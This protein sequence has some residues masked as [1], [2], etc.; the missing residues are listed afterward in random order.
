MKRRRHAG[1]LVVL[2]SLLVLSILIYD[3][4]GWKDFFFSLP[5]IVELAV[6]LAAILLSAALASAL[7]R[8]RKKR[9]K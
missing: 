7:K 5:L 6:I 8:W 2:L 3:V 1:S 4:P 9:R